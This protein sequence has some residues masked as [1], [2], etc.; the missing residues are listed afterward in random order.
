M[1]QKALDRIRE[2]R[3]N[4]GLGYTLRWLGEKASQEVLGTY[5]IGRAHV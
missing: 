3:E 2:T 4:H 5:E 1:F